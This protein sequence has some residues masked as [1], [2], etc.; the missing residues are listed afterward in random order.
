MLYPDS[1]VIVGSYVQC[2]ISGLMMISNPKH[3]A[4]TYAPQYRG[5]MVNVSLC[6][7]FWYTRAKY[8]E[9]YIYMHIIWAPQAK[10]F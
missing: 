2:H 3:A 10:I 6:P 7:F 9:V 4:V 8:F 5:G 1:V